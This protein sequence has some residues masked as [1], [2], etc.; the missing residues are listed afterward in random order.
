VHSGEPPHPVFHPVELV[1]LGGLHRTSYGG[2]CGSDRAGDR[3]DDLKEDAA[4]AWL[5]VR[6]SGDECASIEHKR[7]KRAHSLDLIG[8]ARSQ[9]SF[10]M[11]IGATADLFAFARGDWSR[12]VGR[13]LP[14]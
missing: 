14:Q 4:K 8:N 7:E 3:W 2:G 12:C 5:A 6:R 9:L 11:D 10:V 13:T 1:V